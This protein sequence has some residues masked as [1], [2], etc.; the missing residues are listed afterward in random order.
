MLEEKQF[1]IQ[2]LSPDWIR[3]E[4]FLSDLRDSAVNRSSLESSEGKTK[5]SNPW[6]R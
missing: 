2:S 4:I 3:R 1:V 6:K 5:V